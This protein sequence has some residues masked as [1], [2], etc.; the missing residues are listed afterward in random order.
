MD[1]IEYI[2]LPFTEYLAFLFS[3]ILPYLT[4]PC[5]ALRRLALP[6]FAV[7]C[8]ALPWRILT[9]PQDF[10]FAQELDLVLC[11]IQVVSLHYNY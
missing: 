8:S 1:G 9:E 11:L 2:D 6:C 3:I 4:L 7:L 10:Q 5:L